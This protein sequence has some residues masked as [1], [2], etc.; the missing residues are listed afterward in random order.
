MTRDE[1]TWGPEDDQFLLSLRDEGDP[2]ADDAVAARDGFDRD[3]AFGRE[4][5]GWIDDWFGAGR[6]CRPTW[7]DDD[8]LEIGQD[9][10]RRQEW[11]VNVAFLLGS[12]PKSYGGASGA[13]VLARS[14][15][16][17]DRPQHRIFESALLIRELTD[18]EGLAD[19][20]DGRP[21]DRGYVTVLRLR[22]LHAAVRRTLLAEGWDGAEGVPINQLDLLGTLWCFSLTS[23]AALRKAGRE[24][25]DLELEGWVHL[26]C[27]IGHHLG[28]RPDL[29][30]M[31]PAE[32]ERC[33]DA[34][35]R[36]QFRRSEEG[37]AL[38]GKLVE[39]GHERVPFTAKD[40]LVEALIRRNIGDHHADM[41]DVE[42]ADGADLSQAEWF[43]HLC[44]REAAPDHPEAV[45]G[46]N[47]VARY[48]LWK[49]VR[50]LRDD[51]RRPEAKQRLVELYGVSD[52][53][54]LPDRW[55]DVPDDF[56]PDR[57]DDRPT[58]PEGGAAGT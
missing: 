1:R 42:V 44:T 16:L 35:Q 29:L 22:L 55:E 3:A 12:L 23:A 31:G 48:L 2:V 32:A 14:G 57:P 36:H 43:W 39:V 33:F 15:G 37:C 17:T 41:L 20:L 40:H 27:V 6:P 26:W 53:A 13:K 24:V 30:P 34:I 45:R 47:K 25:T 54:D 50:H 56:G 21:P 9:F 52:L 10:Y 28:V 5:V 38:M 19:G 4:D 8:L 58:P 11:S 46:R 7:Q 49:V 51:A 18:E